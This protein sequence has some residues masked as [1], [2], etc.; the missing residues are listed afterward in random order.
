MKW[1][2][3]LIFTLMIMTLGFAGN[4]H[5]AEGDYEELSWE[6]K[7]KVLTN[8]AMEYNIPPE[9]LKAIATAESDM[10]QF[11]DGEIRVSDD[12]GIGMMQITNSDFDFDEEK[13]KTDTAYNIE[14]GAKILDAK[15]N[16][17]DSGNLPEINGADNRHIIE[18][19]YFPIMAYNGFSNR[20]N[21]NNENVEITYQRK[22]FN[23]IENKS[24]V[25]V[26]ETPVTFDLDTN[27]NGELQFDNSPYDWDEADAYTTQ[28]YK[29]GDKVFVM[30]N[31]DLNVNDLDYG[32]LRSQLDFSS[33]VTMR[34]P[35]Y[36]ELEITGG[37][38]FENSTFD[39]QFITYKVEGSNISGYMS[40]SNLHPMDSLQG[41]INWE[42]SKNDVAIDK[43][44]NIKMNTQIDPASVNERNVYM[45]REDG[46]GI[47]AD[48]SVTDDGN[49]ILVEPQY[50]YMPGQKYTLHIKDIIS[51]QGKKMNTTTA[52]NFVVEKAYT[53]QLEEDNVTFEASLN[54]KTFY[55]DDRIRATATIENNGDEAYIHQGSS[56][57][58]DKI[59]FF[60]QQDGE[61]TQFVGTGDVAP[62]NCTADMVNIE[63]EAGEK[64]TAYA[65]FDLETEELGTLNP[66]LE[67]AKSGEYTLIARYGDKLIEMPFV[68]Q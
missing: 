29:K 35:Y 55:E 7:H 44:W 63:L 4:V 58:D 43:T 56:T 10:M 67:A 36:T 33:D 60:I 24:F 8:I 51:D 65:T 47:R 27:D 11:E 62:R 53:D 34:V 41:E 49:H 20:N 9:I 2:M 31:V 6:K 45:V 21:P 13:L 68:I 18:Q 14:A 1:T 25:D 28:M 30:N 32:N 23:I 40:S 57:C 54:Q 50:D 42:E 52:M 59:F 64:R 61:R 3:S 48:V 39:N 16:L 37:P 66:E 19:W 22:V 38:Y 15:W 17:M 46:V 26:A 5:A 12:G